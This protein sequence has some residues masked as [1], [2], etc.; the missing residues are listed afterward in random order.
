MRAEVAVVTGSIN[1]RE[2]M[3]MLHA[4][5]CGLALGAGIASHA[6]NNGDSPAVIGRWIEV[7]AED[8]VLT[9]RI[10]HHMV[11]APVPVE[12]A[13]ARAHFMAFVRVL[14]ECVPEALT[15]IAKERS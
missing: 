1:A 10:F 7:I 15:R 4:I 12:S 8:S 13:A 2:R 14:V 3:L 5:S 6:A 11:N 9:E